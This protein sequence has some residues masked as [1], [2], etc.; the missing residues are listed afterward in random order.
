MKH[1][2]PILAAILVIYGVSAYVLYVPPVAEALPANPVIERNR[3]WN[4]FVS[5]NK[6]TS[7]LLHDVQGYLQANQ[8]SAVVQNLDASAILALDKAIKMRENETDWLKKLRKEIV[9]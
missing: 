5:S 9:K 6:V 2:L 8:S 1:F 3:V 4:E 7:D